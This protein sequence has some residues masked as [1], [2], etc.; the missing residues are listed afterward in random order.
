[1][2][3]LIADAFEARGVEGLKRAGCEV[4]H[5]PS[6]TQETLPAA[7]KESGADVLIVRSTVV[8]AAALDAG[9]LALVVRAGAGTNT[10][11]V[12]AASRQG[13]WVANCPGKN[14]IAVCELTFAFLLAQDRHIVE[15]AVDLRAKNFDKKTYTKASGLFGRTLGLVGVGNIGS[16]VAKRARAFGIRVVGVSRRLSPERA[17]E[18]DIERAEN[19]L[20]VARVSDFV[21]VHLALTKDTRGSLSTEFFGAMKKGALFVNTARA[22]L[23]DEPA[24]VAAVSSGHVRAAVDVYAGEPESGKGVIDSALLALPG[25]IGAHHIGASTEQAQEAIA[26]ETVRV[27]RAFKETGRVPNAVNLSEKSPASHVLSVRHYDRVGVLAAVFTC[28]R[29]AGL[30]AEEMEN[31]VFEGANAAIARIHVS[32]APTS[33]L[34]A[35]LR[36]AS[37][38]ILDVSV[39]AL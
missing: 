1:M 9:R 2:K 36:A 5:T 39:V 17:A 33:E 38:E 8:T 25:V 32:H 28:L 7:V 37:P 26:D 23:V 24:L 3:V 15:G 31:V 12:P 29:V 21:S 10:I 11:D 4:V 13:I 35:A 19:V 16:E 30:N 22:E 27:V 18:L 20:D 34:V 6:L 14:A